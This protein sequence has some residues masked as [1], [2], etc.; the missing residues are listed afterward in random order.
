MSTNPFDDPNAELC[1]LANNEGQHSLWPAFAPVPAG[2]EMVHGPGRREE[3]EDYVT[4]HW[5]DLRP[6]SLRRTMDEG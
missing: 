6:A 5:T 2:W 4:S 3:A 1:V